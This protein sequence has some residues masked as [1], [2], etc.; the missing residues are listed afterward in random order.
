MGTMRVALGCVEFVWVNPVI[1]FRPFLLLYSMTQI[2]F[3]R[4]CRDSETTLTQKQGAILRP[5]SKINF[6]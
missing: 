5:D 3:S 4:V 2:T 6:W 1:H